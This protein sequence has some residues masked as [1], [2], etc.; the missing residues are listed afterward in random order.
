MVKTIDSVSQ[1]AET[2][3]ASTQQMLA[4]VGS[5]SKSIENVAGISEKIRPRQKKF[6]HLLKR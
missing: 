1:S 3:S 2:N 5:I 4:H 6:Q